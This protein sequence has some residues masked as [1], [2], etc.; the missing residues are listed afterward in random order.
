MKKIK[1]CKTMPKQWLKVEKMEHGVKPC[2]AKWVAEEKKEPWH[3][4]LKGK[5]PDWKLW[6]AEEK[7]EPQHKRKKGDASKLINIY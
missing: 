3:K 6:M 7:K 5:N 4:S 1:S 2:T